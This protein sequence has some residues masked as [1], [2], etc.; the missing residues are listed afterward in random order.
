MKS[1]L[2]AR[3]SAT[4]SP[5]MTCTAHW[6]V[7]TGESD[8]NSLSFDACK[9]VTTTKVDENMRTLEIQSTP[10]SCI[11]NNIC[12]K[13]VSYGWVY[14]RKNTSFNL[15]WCLKT[16][17]RIII[18]RRGW[19]TDKE[20]F[21]NLRSKLGKGCFFRHTR[22]DEHCTPYCGKLTIIIFRGSPCAN[23][24]SFDPFL[25]CLEIQKLPKAFWNSLKHNS[26]IQKNLRL[27]INFTS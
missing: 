24:S 21:R 12:W 26:L 10:S 3:S 13:L 8:E 11:F 7:K 4:R 17:D 20:L 1:C 16:D 15:P 2:A 14:S 6:S 9:A 18:S 25:A 27:L 23:K 19:C 5:P 22:V